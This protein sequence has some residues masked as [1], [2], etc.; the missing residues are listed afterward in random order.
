M[1]TKSLEVVISEDIEQQTSFGCRLTFWKR[2]TIVDVTVI[3]VL[4]VAVV[5][6]VWCWCVVL[7]GVVMVLLLL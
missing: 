5:T 6:G 3:V 1:T 2:V 4:V 7:V